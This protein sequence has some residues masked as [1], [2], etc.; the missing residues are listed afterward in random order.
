MIGSRS[1]PFQPA[2]VAENTYFQQNP[3][4]RTAMNQARTN[5]ENMFDG[6]GGVPN[7]QNSLYLAPTAGQEYKFHLGLVNYQPSLGAGFNYR[8]SS[9][10]QSSSANGGYFTFLPSVSFYLGDPAGTRTVNLDYSASAEEPSRNQNAYNQQITLN[11]HVEFAKTSFGLGINYSGLSGLN[12]DVGGNARSNILT[13]SL[14]STYL[15]SEKSSFDLDF[16]LPVRQFSGGISSSGATSTFGYNYILSTKTTVG[17]DITLGTL[18][19]NG[20]SAQHYVDPCLNIS[21]QAS[22][23]LSIHANAG[24]DLRKAGS[25][26]SINPIFGFGVAWEPRVGTSLTLSGERKVQN[27]ASIAGANFTSTSITLSLSQ[28]IARSFTGTI[29]AGFEDAPYYSVQ[30]GVSTNRDDLSCFLQ[31]GISTKFARDWSASLTVSYEDTVSNTNPLRSL[32]T[33]LQ[34]TYLF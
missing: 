23:K 2:P 13:V 31:T 22:S 33:S 4:A 27:S 15:Y 1:Q 24:I 29:S 3:L 5:A 25:T 30:T 17:A 9:G 6:L 14:T 19:V 16:T 8:T 21:Y 34:F 26:S 28:K 18:D 7:P 10:N 12:R 20:G 11:S 32:Q